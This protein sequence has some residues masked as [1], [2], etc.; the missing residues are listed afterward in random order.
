MRVEELRAPEEPQY[1]EFLR[2]REEALV[3]QSTKYKR[4]LRELLGCEERYLVARSEDGQIRGV[5]PLLWTG[6]DGARIYNSLPFYGSHGG[7]IADDDETT[8]TLLDAYAAIATARGTRCSTVVANPLAPEPPAEPIHNL[9]DERVSQVTP[10]P[11]PHA[12]PEA[13][14]LDGIDSSAR[15]NVRKAREHGITVSVDHHEMDELRRLH[16]ANIRALGG[17]PKSDDFFACLSRHFRP[18]ADYDI[19]VARSGSLVVAALLVLYCNQTAE[20][21]TPAV[22]PEFRSWQPLAP[23]LVTAMAAAATRGLRYWNWGGTWLTQEGVYRFKRKWGARESRYSYYVQL[24]DRELLRRSPAEVM[25]AH[26][27]FYVVPTAA[28]HS[29]P[30]GSP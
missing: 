13:V 5:L 2:G 24:N 22:D 11:A 29:S 14:I 20:Y 23:I 18:S 8:R 15:R 1:D 27:H 28:F 17:L 3:Y 25:A 19:Y 30:G 9:S 16:Q 12:D 4:F 7:V 21:F 10:L 6:A 26:R